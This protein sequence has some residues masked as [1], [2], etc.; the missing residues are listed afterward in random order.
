M[1]IVR[2]NREQSPFHF[3]GEQYEGVTVVE[4]TLATGD[5]SLAG[6]ESRVA[7]E[8]K[9][10]ADFVAS[11]STGRDRFERELA[12]ARGLDAFMVVV[13]APFSDLA[14]GSYRSR[15]K[16]KA[17]TQTVYSFMSRYRATFHFAQNRAWAEYATFHF[18]RHYAR[19]MERE[20]KAAVAA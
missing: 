19:Q 9:S 20:Y 8:R 10:L 2:D 7:V 3:V 11:I 1:K 5:Y 17:A 18:L 13:E 15:M 16:P 12:R 4:G 14:A 6:L